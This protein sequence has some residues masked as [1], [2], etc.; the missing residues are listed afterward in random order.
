MGPSRRCGLPSQPWGGPASHSGFAGGSFA[1]LTAGPSTLD[2]IRR[3]RTKSARRLSHRELE[4]AFP[5]RMPFLRRLAGAH[6]GL[7]QFHRLR[8]HVEAEA[9][10]EAGDAQDAY[11]VLAES[12]AHLLF[13]SVPLAGLHMLK[14]LIE[15]LDF[16]LVP[17]VGDMDT[18]LIIFQPHCSFALHARF[19]LLAKLELQ[20]FHHPAR[21][22]ERLEVQSE[23]G[24]QSNPIS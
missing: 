11:R 14:Q 7:H 9:R 6:H 12:L 3:P 24:I 23:R 10:G 19:D 22:P 13:I 20:F 4:H 21:S 17:E 5:A 1:D 18:Q 2:A 16:E 15:L 8:E